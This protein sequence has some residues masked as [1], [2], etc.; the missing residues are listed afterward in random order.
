MLYG[1]QDKLEKEKQNVQ[2]LREQLDGDKS[3]LSQQILDLKQTMAEDG[4]RHEIQKS[5]LRDQLN[6]VRFLI[7]K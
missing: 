7:A 4:T 1:F 5:E 3:S 6:R 2:T